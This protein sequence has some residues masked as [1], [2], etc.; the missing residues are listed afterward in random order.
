MG[1]YGVF[2]IY[3][4]AN[5]MCVSLSLINLFINVNTGGV[6]VAAGG[7]VFEYAEGCE[8]DRCEPEGMIEEQREKGGREGGEREKVRGRGKQVEGNRGGYTLYR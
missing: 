5:R 8:R 4:N 7:G 3:V 6:T 1:L 2:V